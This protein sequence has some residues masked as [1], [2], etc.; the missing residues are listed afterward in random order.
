MKILMVSNMYPSASDVYFGSFIRNIKEGFEVNGC[1][2]DLIAIKGQ[3]VGILDKVKKY[4][5]FY[6][7]I[8]RV[9]LND[10]DIVHIS[11][12]SHTYLPFIV[13]KFGKCKKVIRLHGLEIVSDKKNDKL[14]RLRKFFTRISCL[15]VN[16]IVVPSRYFKNEAKKTCGDKKYYT[17]PSGGI[18]T[19]RFHITNEYTDREHDLLNIGCVGRVDVLKG[20]DKLIKS[21]AS[22]EFPYHLHI[23]GKGPLLEEMKSLAHELD[24]NATFYGAIDNHKLIEYYNKFGVFVFPTE[25]PGESFGNVALEA[26]ICGLPLIGSRFAGVTEYLDDEKNGLF[27]EKGNVE[28]LNRKLVKFNHMDIKEKSDM[29]QCAKLSALKF[30][31]NKISKEFVD[32]MCNL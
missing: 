1:E 22:V 10:Y 26:M 4:L 28:D 20:V 19:K 25:R 27:F 21:L 9:N 11:Y 7:A 18:D 16:T 12:P 6:L 17:Y 32:Y 29:S 3:G 14:L 30:E 24:V 5:S 8:L 31:K 23:I 13:K 2:V 15:N